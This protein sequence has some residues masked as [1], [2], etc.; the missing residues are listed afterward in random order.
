MVKFAACL[1]SGGENLRFDSHQ[2]H[3]NCYQLNH[4]SRCP[5]LLVD[6]GVTRNSFS[7]YP[8]SCPSVVIILT[9]LSM[10]AMCGILL[11]VKSVRS[12]IRVIHHC[13]L[14]LSFWRIRN[15]FEKRPQCIWTRIAF[16]GELQQCVMRIGKRI[17]S[18]P[19]KTKG[20]SLQNKKKNHENWWKNPNSWRNRKKIMWK[21]KK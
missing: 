11:G 20:V 3:K 17:D 16:D 13:P 21:W 5:A 1:L 2:K 6:V 4:F 18:N 15:Q 12:L 9:T 10:S 7:K 19:N 14:H 8:A